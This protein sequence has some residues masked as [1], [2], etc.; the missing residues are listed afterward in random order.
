[1]TNPPTRRLGVLAAT[2][3]LATG[4]GLVAAVP[5]SADPPPPSGYLL[6]KSTGSYYSLTAFTDLSARPGST[7]SFAYQIVNNGQTD[8]QYRIVLFAPSQPAALYVS[9]TP[10]GTAQLVKSNVYYTPPI[11]AGKTFPLTI[12]VTVPSGGMDIAYGGQLD[13][14]DPSVPFDPTRFDNTALDRAFP[15]AVRAAPTAG[16]TNQDLFLSTGAQ[17]RVGGSCCD[18]DPAAGVFHPTLS[19]SAI[20]VGSAVS[21]TLRLQNDGTAPSAIPLHPEIFG[22]LG[23]TA[24]VTIRTGFTDVSSA[25]L[26][27]TYVT[28]SLAPGAHRDFT[29]TVKLV[30]CAASS[31]YL[32]AA[33][34]A[35]DKVQ[36][37]AYVPVAA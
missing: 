31:D 17:P 25:V 1:M 36:V 33:G 19:S 22:D 37:F 26:A 35:T 6:S 27:G 28:P 15:T 21:F 29:V 16:T 8:S 3:I 14:Q 2:A 30:N 24:N 9:Q 34:F 7:V 11:A 4:I 12:K 20:K 32:W 18:P 13:L 10:T 23:C 5:A